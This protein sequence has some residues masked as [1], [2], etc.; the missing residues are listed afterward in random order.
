[1]TNDKRVEKDYKNF[2]KLAEEMRSYL[3]DQ[4]HGWNNTEIAMMINE[5]DALTAERR[6]AN[7]ESSDLGNALRAER[8]MTDDLQSR[9]QEAEQ[10]A[11]RLQEKWEK[12]SYGVAEKEMEEFKSRLQEAEQ[13]LQ[14][15]IKNN[16]VKDSTLASCKNV[17]IAELEKEVER[18]KGNEYYTGFQMGQEHE[19]IKIKE[20]EKEISD[21]KYTEQILTDTAIKDAEKIQELETRIEIEKF[22]AKK[23]AE[24]SNKL[25]AR[26]AESEAH[27]S[28][29][30]KNP[31]L[32]ME[33]ISKLESEL[34]RHK[35]VVEA[36]KKLPELEC[37]NVGNFKQPHCEVCGFYEALA[38][39]DGDKLQ[40]GENVH[41]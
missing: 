14:D 10:K 8:R 19:Q 37:K 36:A 41:P 40:G 26:L 32:L 38:S 39:L 22:W 3:F 13:K 6:R 2:L 28:M 5:S 27:N 24:K 34:S 17:K 25:E 7:K 9:L 31:E 23:H 21:R 11:F 15:Q 35:A 29:L 20:L 16:D 1:M 30:V 33:R 4:G 12:F 18:L